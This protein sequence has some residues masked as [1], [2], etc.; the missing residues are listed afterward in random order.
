MKE[1]FD[2]I[3]PVL[4]FILGFAINWFINRRE[5]YWRFYREKELQLLSEMNK[6]IRDLCLSFATDPG[7]YTYIFAPMFSDIGIHSEDK[8]Y[9]K[10]FGKNNVLLS[11]R[12]TKNFIL[13]KYIDDP[14]I[15]E[16]IRKII[17]KFTDQFE[18]VDK[19][20]VESGKYLLL[21][22]WNEIKDYYP[23]DIG[24]GA[25]KLSFYQFSFISNGKYTYTDYHSD[26]KDLKLSIYKILNKAIHKI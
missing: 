18:K 24:K 19:K 15:P 16:D 26:L 3:L 1:I 22:E 13:K 4:T 9:I 20:T 21:C 6:D 17:R 11:E 8:S 5:F 25:E 10:T 23:N 12:L 14:F 7:P 2:T